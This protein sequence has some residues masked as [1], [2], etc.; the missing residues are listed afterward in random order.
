[1]RATTQDYAAQTIRSRRAGGNPLLHAKVAMR[2][3]GAGARVAIGSALALFHDR[4][5]PHGSSQ[6]T[7]R[8]SVLWCRFSQVEW[9]VRCLWRVEHAD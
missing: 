8:L 2:A 9:Q 4:S 7:L 3:R 5:R 1:M 6:L